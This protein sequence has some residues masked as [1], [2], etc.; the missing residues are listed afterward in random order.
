MSSRIDMKI[1]RIGI[2]NYG[3]PYTVNIRA[4]VEALDPL[5]TIAEKFRQAAERAIPAQLT[6]S[7]EAPRTT[8]TGMVT[9]ED[10]EQV[11]IQGLVGMK[12]SGQIAKEIARRFGGRRIAEG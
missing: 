2:D 8:T 9:A 5:K 1:I 11:I 6:V 7:G 3:E 12:H 10:L 4:V